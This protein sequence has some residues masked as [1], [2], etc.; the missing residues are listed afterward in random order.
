[1]MNNRKFRF[2]TLPAFLAAMALTVVSASAQNTNGQI[3]SNHLQSKINQVE[4]WNRYANTFS[5]VLDSV[6]GDFQKSVFE[7]D[8][9][10]NCVKIDNYWFYDGWMYDYTEKYAYDE[11]DRITMI[12]DSTEGYASKSVFLYENGDWISDEY[13]YE[14]DGEDWIVFGKYTYEYDTDGHMV[15]SVGYALEE[16]WVPES[17]MTWE[18]EDGKLQNDIYYYHGENSWNP[19]TRNDYYYNA[20]GLCRER[21]QSHWEGD[22]TAG[23][24][25]E[26]EYDEAGNRHIE[27]TST[28]YEL[29]DW[30]Y[31]YMTEYLYDA[32]GNCYSLSGYY[33]DDLRDWELESTM[34]YNYDLAV[35]VEN[36]AGIWMVWDEEMPLHNKLL[37]WQ[38]WANDD[39]YTTTFYY[40]K[41][42]GLNEE[43]ESL[44][45]VYP[46]PASNIARI[47][48]VI[49][50]EVQVYNALGQ[51]V[52]TVRGSNE[53]PVMDLPQGIYLLRIADADGKV[54]TNKITIR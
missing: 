10:F 15:L 44:L 50:N 52:K 9:H 53:I 3:T 40:S 13:E 41:C 48:G 11:R 31:T 28:I 21:L 49:A 32:N 30:V 7:Y 38:L 34:T 20:E 8:E 2:G 1:M 42:E 46:N 18:Y 37:D 23:W 22:W 54:Y 19:I 25:V 36:I 24:K 16:D 43:P 14:L 6:Y 45:A 12:M 35:P 4:K 5:E 47:D 29:D 51:L 17:K 33:N 27:T 39:A 26:Y